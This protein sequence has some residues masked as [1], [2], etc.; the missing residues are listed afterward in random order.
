MMIHLDNAGW[1]IA[2]KEPMEL[3]EE[4]LAGEHFLILLCADRV[5]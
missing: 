3:V 5:H 2:R 4:L 1:G